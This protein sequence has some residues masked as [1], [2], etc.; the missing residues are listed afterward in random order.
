MRVQNVLTAA[1]T[2]LLLFSCSKDDS[3]N[4]TDEESSLKTFASRSQ[5]SSFT[6]FIYHGK[7]MSLFTL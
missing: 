5:E 2:G 6:S 1:L 3:I 7:L 4:Y